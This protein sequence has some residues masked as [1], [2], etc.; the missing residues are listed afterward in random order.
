MKKVAATFD[1]ENSLWKQNK[2]YIVG[3]D[4]VGRG[5]W[6][7]PLVA[8][9]VVLPYR[10]VS[11][12]EF[13]DSKLLNFSQRASLS[14][15]IKEESETFGIGEVSVSEVISL[16]LTAATQLAYLRAVEQLKVMPEHY[17]IDAF[18]LASIPKELQTPIIHGDRLS[19]SIAAAS[20][21][22]KSYRDQVMIDRANEYKKYGFENNKGYGTVFH[23]KAIKE[24]GLSN[25]HRSNYNLKFLA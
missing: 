23:Q 11:K 1:Y 4:E 19:A 2:K 25:F 17:L 14:S 20:I 5:A 21:I 9:A 13:F 12:Q 6:A 10:Y 8:A 15:F 18:Y 22:A 16:G 3:I 7:G 24:F